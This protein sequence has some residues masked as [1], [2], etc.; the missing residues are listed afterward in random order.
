MK[1]VFFSLAFML[2]SSFAIANNSEE[3]KSKEVS[4]L[5]NKETSFTFYSKDKNNNNVKYEYSAQTDSCTITSITQYVSNGEVTYTHTTLM[6]IDGMSCETFIKLM[7][8][9]FSAFL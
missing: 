9:D 2:I 3:I 1:H 4:S 5:N 8:I 7:S 6:H